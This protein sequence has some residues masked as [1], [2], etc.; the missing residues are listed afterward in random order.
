M[1]FVGGR[2]SATYAPTLLGPCTIWLALRVCSEHLRG[3]VKVARAR[4]RF[5]YMLLTDIKAPIGSTVL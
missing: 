3:C 4:I 5:A 2:G 1:L